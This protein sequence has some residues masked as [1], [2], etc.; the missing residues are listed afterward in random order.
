MYAA[1]AA[2]NMNTIANRLQ[3][4]RKTL[5][6]TRAAFATKLDVPPPTLRKW[7]NNERQPRGLTA[8]YLEMKLAELEA[9]AASAKA[10]SAR[11]T[12]KAARSS[13]GSAS[14]R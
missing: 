13:Q 14:R 1:K 8:K 9:E 6:L 5:R 10:A 2:G 11:S 3:T 4:I 12:K 7:E